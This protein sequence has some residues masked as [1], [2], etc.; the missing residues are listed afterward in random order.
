MIGPTSTMEITNL[1]LLSTLFGSMEYRKVKNPYKNPTTGEVTTKIM[2]MV[3][4]TSEQFEIT[5]P[6]EITEGTY[7]K[8]QEIDFKGC[9]VRWNA[10]GKKGFKEG[11]VGAILNVIIRATEVVVKDDAFPNE[12]VGAE[13][14]KPD[15]KQA[16]K[17]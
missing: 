15:N 3:D 1:A 12:K 6:G 5:V 11:D 10:S 13:S 14:A 8:G 9:N 7:R 2:I 4:E 17:K 16:V